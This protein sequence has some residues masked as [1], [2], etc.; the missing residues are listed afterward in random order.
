MATSNSKHDSAIKILQTN[1][2]FSHWPAFEPS[3]AE[4]KE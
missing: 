2:K 1:A 4:L 3:T